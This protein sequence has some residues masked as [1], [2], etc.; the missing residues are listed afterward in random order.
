MISS[1][2]FIFK[3]LF[4]NRHYKYYT[5]HHFPPASFTPKTTKQRLPRYPQH[6][7]NRITPL[8]NPILLQKLPKPLL[9]NIILIPFPSMSFLGH[10]YQL[11]LITYFYGYLG[12]GITDL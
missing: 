6:I 5:P 11:A 3:K 9:T 10:F 12:F 4:H 8:H 7:P 2:G 1:L